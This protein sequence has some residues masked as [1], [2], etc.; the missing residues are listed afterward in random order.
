MAVSASTLRTQS[1]S[2]AWTICS[3]RTSRP[4]GRGYDLVGS[5]VGVP[6]LIA[7]VIYHPYFNDSYRDAALVNYLSASLMSMEGEYPGCRFLLS[8]DFNC[9]NIR[10][11]TIQFQQKHLVEKPTRGN[12][13][14]DLVITNF[15]NSTKRTHWKPFPFGLSN[16][17]VVLVHPKV[18]P[19]GKGSSRKIVSRRDT[20]ASRKVELGHYF[21]TIDWSLFNCVHSCLA[22][23]SL[24]VDTI[25]IGIDHIM[26]VM[27]Q[28]IHVND[29]P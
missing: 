4:C 3:I 14:L 18:R 7:G 11:L 1:N 17:K 29:V 12:Q 21:S 28:K 26:P 25:H 10:R 27:H 23:L 9:L 2:S 19:V 16:H 15:P 22:K 20:G 8:R 5:H 13:I 6:C 24:F